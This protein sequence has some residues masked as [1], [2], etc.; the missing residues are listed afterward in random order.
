MPERI[1]PWLR[2]EIAL[3]GTEVVATHLPTPKVKERK[4]GKN[5]SLETLLGLDEQHKPWAFF[6]ELE[7]ELEAVDWD[8]L[9]IRL[10][11]RLAESTLTELKELLL[12][13]AAMDQQIT[14]QR[15]QQG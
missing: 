4:K 7:G 11:E 1:D 9:S 8:Q 2:G 15:L 10:S 14:R 5:S 3:Y 6:P 12:A 13:L